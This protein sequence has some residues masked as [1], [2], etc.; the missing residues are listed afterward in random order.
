[1]DP[2]RAAV[3]DARA[4]D[5]GAFE[6]LVLRYQARIVNYASAIVHDAGAAEDVAQET[7]VRAWRGLGRFRGESAFKTW[8]YRIATNVARTHLDRRGRQARIGDRSLDDET[9]PLQAGDVPSP[10]PDAETSLVRREA[11]DRALAELPDELRAALVLRDVEG[12]DYKEIAGVTG[13]PIGTVESRIFR[14]RRRLRTLL[15]PLVT[16]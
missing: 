12:L 8:L 14:A 11:I 15:R 7:F 5:G 9:E 2:D 3:E 4:G 10:A 6:A 1:M 16:A 13:A